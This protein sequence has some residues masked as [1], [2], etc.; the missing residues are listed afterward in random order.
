VRR[1]LALS[2]LLAIVAMWGGVPLLHVHAYG[3]HEHSEHRHGLAAHEHAH[4]SA[5]VSH[6]TDTRQPTLESCEPGQHVVS[7]VMR[8]ATVSVFSIVLIET[9]SPTAARPQSP[10]LA[11]PPFDDVRV[12]GPPER[13]RPPARAPPLAFPA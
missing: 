6:H 7:L 1:A 4:A 8:G 11:L 10:L 2:S 3:D 9:E 5:L 13:A 12:H